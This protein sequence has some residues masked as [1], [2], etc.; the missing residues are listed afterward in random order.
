[1]SPLAWAFLLLLAAFILLVIEMFVPSHGVIGAIAAICVGAAVVAGF[2]QGLAWGVLMLAISA[3]S[4][5]IAVWA[6]FMYWPQTPLGQKILIKLPESP[7]EVLPE[8]YRDRRAL[9]GKIGISKSKMLLAGAISIDGKQYD[10]VSEDLPIEE[11]ME[12]QVVAIKMNGI[13][14][15]ALDPNRPR[16]MRPPVVVNSVPTATAVNAASAGSGLAA[17]GQITA[18]PV[19]AS[20]VP[21][22][23]QTPEDLLARS[24]ASFGLEDIEELTGESPAKEPNSAKPAE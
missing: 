8:S 9:I 15:R 7:D 3:V 5:P 22:A 23:A 12:V 6:V 10:A 16:E 14:V 21:L 17:V 20:M 19:P 1:M 4:V 18:T 24:A 13:V 11:G 2:Y